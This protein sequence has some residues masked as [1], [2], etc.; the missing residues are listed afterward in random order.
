MAMSKVKTPKPVILLIIAF[1]CPTE[2]SLYLD[3]LRIPPHRLMLM[4]LLPLALFRLLAQRNL[5]IH[6]FDIAFFLF[7]IWTVGIFMYHQGQHDGLVYGGSLALDGMG[8]YLVARCWIRDFAL[9]HA[10][11]RTMGWAITAAALIA[12]PETLLGQNFTH[13]VLKVVTGYFHP[14]AVETRMGLTRAYGTFDHPIHY[15]AFC[16]ALLAQFWYAASTKM[17]RRKRAA[18]LA[19]ATLLGLSSAPLLCLGLQAAMLVWEY[20]TRGTANRTAVALAVLA[21]LYLGAAMVMERSPINLI[22]TGMT[23]DP[24]T[25]YYRLQIWEHGIENVRANPLT[26]IGLGDWK[27]PWWMVSSTVDAFWLVILMREGIPA[28]VMLGA[29]IVFAMRA[30]VK[31]GLRNPDVAVRRLSR[32]WIMSLIALSL[33]GCT[34]HY[35]NVLYAFFF[36]FIGLSG[37][38]ADPKRRRVAAKA[39]HM[40]GNPRTP[41]PVLQSP[42]WPS[43]LPGHAGGYG[44][45][46]APA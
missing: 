21:G 12:L 27:R 11:L 2:F 33:V 17:E 7:N 15:G 42:V 24:W 3:G 14:T 41:Q 10:V 39:K 5:K 34:V 18:L 29:G 13:D 36:F 19:L 31:R 45:M 4:V 28:L 25:G 40:L 9:F 32:G 35:W 46:A 23:L 44:A 8:A 6:G 37:W 43:Q 22:A 38:I 30:V 1:L 20:L 26:G 16:A